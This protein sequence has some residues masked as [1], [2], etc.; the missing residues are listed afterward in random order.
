MAGCYKDGRQRS[1]RERCCTLKRE[2]RRKKQKQ[3]ERGAM[4]IPAGHGPIPRVAMLS[5]AHKDL[6]GT[7]RTHPEK[8]EVKRALGKAGGKGSQEGDH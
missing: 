7:P 2:V 1:Y 3:R 6:K 5:K 8:R 4:V